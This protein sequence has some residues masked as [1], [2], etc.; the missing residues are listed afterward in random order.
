MDKSRVQVIMFAIV[1]VVA[2]ARPVRASEASYMATWTIT[3]STVAPWKSQH[4]EAVQSGIKALLGKTV[5]FQPKRIV[6]PRPLAC[7]QPNYE[8]KLYAAD[9]LFQGGLTDPAKQAAA[10]GFQGAAI[11]TLE[12][13]C[14]GAIDFHFVSPLKAEFALNNRIYILERLGH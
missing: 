3:S 8:M 10:L 11:Q 14:E 1:A 9:M 13:G 4:E 7:A 12:T 5:T 6:A 2:W